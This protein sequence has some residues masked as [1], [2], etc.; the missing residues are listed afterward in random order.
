MRDAFPC[1]GLMP[2]WTNEKCDVKS[3]IYDARKIEY[4]I[5]SEVRSDGI[6]LE[7]NKEKEKHTKGIFIEQT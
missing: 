2:I 7:K 1:V 3:C 5:R 6:L 4:C